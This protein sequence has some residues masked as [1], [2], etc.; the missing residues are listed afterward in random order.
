MQSK[1]GRPA[2]FSDKTAIII[3]LRSINGD[4]K[5]KVSRFLKMQLAERGFVTTIEVKS[6][7]R[8][9]PTKCYVLTGKGKTYLN[10]SKNWK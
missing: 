2:I 8:G 3:A 4:E 9:R 1:V 6:G 5:V 7:N 10:F